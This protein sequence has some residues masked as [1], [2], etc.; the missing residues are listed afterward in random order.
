MIPELETALREWRDARQTFFDKSSQFISKAE[1][2]RLA[3]AERVLMKL[4]KELG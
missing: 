1:Y 3:N 4:A 2:D